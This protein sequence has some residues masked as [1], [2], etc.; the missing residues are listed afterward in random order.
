MQSGDDF[1][2]IGKNNPFKFSNDVPLIQE[3]N[4]DKKD[5]SFHNDCNIRPYLF[6][7]LHGRF[8][9]HLFQTFS[10]YSCDLNNILVRYSGQKV[11]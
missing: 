3:H 10:A 6:V 5:I 9:N 2:M 11:V 7:L 8:G 1:Y 4:S